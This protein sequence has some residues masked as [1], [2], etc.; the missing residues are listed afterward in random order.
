MFI[1]SAVVGFIMALLSKVGIKYSIR[2]AAD[3]IEVGTFRCGSPFMVVFHLYDYMVKKFV[4]ATGVDCT[5]QFAILGVILAILF[6]V[7]LVTAELAY[8]AGKFLFDT[9]AMVTAI[10]T[11][12]LVGMWS[13]TMRAF[14]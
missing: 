11:D 14:A 7:E 13:M 9:A 1:I 3:E 4:K 10:I 8:V 12:S 2:N 5:D 6:C